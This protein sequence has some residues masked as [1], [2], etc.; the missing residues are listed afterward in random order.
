MWPLLSRRHFAGLDR[1]GCEVLVMVGRSDVG[2]TCFALDVIFPVAAE[3]V[4]ASGSLPMAVLC[5]CEIE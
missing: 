5:C 4:E 1:E 2:L 3:T